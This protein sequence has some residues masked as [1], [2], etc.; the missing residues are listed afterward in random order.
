M[1]L[2]K[3]GNG[4]G[5]AISNCSTLPTTH[6]APP[7][8]ILNRQ[9]HRQLHR[10]HLAPPLF[11]TRG[12]GPSSGAPSVACP[13]SDKC[14]EAVGLCRD[15]TRMTKLYNTKEEL[16]AL[17]PENEDKLVDR[18]DGKLRFRSDR[19][20]I[21]HISHFCSILPYSGSANHVPL[22]DIDPPDYPLDWHTNNTPR[23]PYAGPYGCT[24]TLPRV[25]HSRFRSF[26]TPRTH[27]TKVSARRDV[28]FQAYRALYENGLL[29]EHLLPP[30]DVLKSE[31]ESEVRI[32]LKEVEQREG[33]AL[34]SSQM[35]PWRCSGDNMDAVPSIQSAR[36]G[37]GWRSGQHAHA[38]RRGSEVGLSECRTVGQ[39]DSQTV[40]QSDSQTVKTVRH[41]QSD[42]SDNR[43][44]QPKWSDCRTKG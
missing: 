29:N 9:F 39:S 17:R 36:Q 13:S 34:V 23:T 27:P 25:L 37:R 40:R 16:R 3:W 31:L 33:T 24:L 18:E 11:W 6:L 21:E 32:L 14:T 42:Q 7:G 12:S 20:A 8:L 38:G 15:G 5:L 22:F 28:A 35:D 41:V 4:N 10:L 19:S 43:T 44:G 2:R 1:W 30:I 26:S